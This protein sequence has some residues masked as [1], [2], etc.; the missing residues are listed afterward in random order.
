MSVELL[1]PRSLTVKCVH[2][3]SN[4]SPERVCHHCGAPLCGDAPATVDVPGERYVNLEF[5]GIPLPAQVRNGQAIHCEAH[6]HGVRVRGRWLRKV[7]LLTLIAGALWSTGLQGWLGP[8]A[9]VFARQVTPSAYPALPW[10]IAALGLF[11]IVLAR[12]VRWATFTWGRR[13][14]RPPFPAFPI[15]DQVRREERIEL[16]VRQEGNGPCQVTVGPI[17]GKILL[18]GRMTGPDH[19]RWGQ[20][21]RVYGRTLAH[22]FETCLGFLA[23]QAGNSVQGSPADFR[24]GVTMLKDRAG[25]FPYLNDPKADPSVTWSW[26]YQA[27]LPQ[28]YER[29]VAPVAPVQVS[30]N[31]TARASRTQLELH[32]HLW[33]NLKSQVRRIEHFTLQLN[34]AWGEVQESIPKFGVAPIRRE[35]EGPRLNEHRW[36]RLTVE[37]ATLPVFTLRFEHPLAPDDLLTGSFELVLKE[38]VAELDL[39]GLYDPLGYRIPDI[40]QQQE[41]VIS[42]TFELSLTG[43]SYPEEAS[44]TAEVLQPGAIPDHRLITRLIQALATEGYY[45]KNI[46]ENPPADSRAAAQIQLRAWDIKGRRYLG[47]QPI[48]FHLVVTGEEHYEGSDLPTWGN[49]RAEIIT[50]GV[51]ATAERLAQIGRTAQHI[52]DLIREELSRAV[53]AMPRLLPAAAAAEEVEQDADRASSD[54][55]RIRQRLERLEELFVEGRITSEQYMELKDQY[56]QALARLRDQGGEQWP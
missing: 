48:D 46:Q 43:L 42:G 51:A 28:P 19:E 25:S 11:L 41:T 52:E 47:L 26:A 7:G 12:L 50:Q 49:T 10:G 15:W 24:A 21:R 4:Q 2:C 39:I 18:S 53:P 8:V 27:D 22:R 40:S 3:F 14:Q 55:E 36:S 37:G 5:Q 30:A 13:R 34:P 23:L 9:S 29:K 38:C 6:R 54:L 35:A 56:E 44:A 45:I 16:Q 32:L 33:S 31:L 17:Q 1:Y 20:F